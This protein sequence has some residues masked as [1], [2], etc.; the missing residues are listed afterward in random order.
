M[1]IENNINRKHVKS[2]NVIFHLT[3]LEN[4]DGILKKGLLCRKDLKGNFE[5]VADPN[6]IVSRTKE[7][8]EKYVPFHFFP[9]N[10]FDGDVFNNHPEKEFIYICI[11][12]KKARTKGFQVIPKHPMSMREFKI[13]SYDEGIA[14]IDWEFMNNRDYKN[15]DCRHVCMAE[16]IYEKMVKPFDFSCIYV[17]NE[18]VKSIVEPKIK[19]YLQKNNLRKNISVYVMEG[20][21]PKRK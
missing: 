4:L 15:D 2:H 17:R 11:S 10:P 8:L 19:E 14:K 20:C 9:K 16:C 13:Y 1:E 5:D 7:E 12:K 6:M 21:F 18:N 3:S